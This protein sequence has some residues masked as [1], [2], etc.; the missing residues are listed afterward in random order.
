LKLDE[1]ISQ[2][3]PLERVNEAFDEMRRGELAR[4]VVGFN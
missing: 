2:R 4:S 3:L 1:L